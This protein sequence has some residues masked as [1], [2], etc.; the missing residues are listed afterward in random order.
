MCRKRRRLLA[1]LLMSAGLAAPCA[2]QAVGAEFGFLS[3]PVGRPD[4]YA[5]AASAGLWGELGPLADVPLVAGAWAAVAGFRSMAA[6][7][8]DSVM[9]YG[10]LE[11]GYALELLD[12]GDVSLTLRPTVRLGWYGRAIEY[13]GE[14]AWGSRPFAAAGALVD[15]RSGGLDLGMSAMASFPLDK[16]PVMLFG[17][18]QRVGLCL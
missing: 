10:G 8:G 11:L 17:L 2:A 18:T 3:L 14:P 12:Y 13:E 6:A 15:L 9:Y 5:Y 4:P 1:V 16:R 7:F